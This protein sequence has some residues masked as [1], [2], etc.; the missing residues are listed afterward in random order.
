MFMAIEHCKPGVMFSKI[1]EVIED[2]AH[3]HGYTVNQEFGGHGI[4][5]E[6]HMSPLVHH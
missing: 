1:G 3:G 5:Q 2:Y 4:G 6:L